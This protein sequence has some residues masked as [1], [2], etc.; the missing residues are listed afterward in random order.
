MLSIFQVALGEFEIIS[1]YKS[2]LKMLLGHNRHV[3]GEIN[4]HLRLH[5]LYTYFKPLLNLK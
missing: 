4:L 2:Q 5:P 1:Y 3:L